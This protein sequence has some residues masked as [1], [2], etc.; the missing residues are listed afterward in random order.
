M[1]ICG[2]HI[3]G[4]GIFR[5]CRLEDLPKGLVLVVGQNESG[6]TTLMEFIR[7][8]LFGFRPRAEN[9]YPPLRGGAHGGRIELGSRDG[10]RF[11]VERRGKKATISEN[12]GPPREQEPASLL[13]GNI[14]RQTFERVFAIGLSDLQKLDVL[15]NDAF[16]GQLLSAGVGLGT[17]S[18]PQ[19]RK[20]L[21][22]ELD[23]LLKSRANQEI[24]KLKL[25]LEQIEVQLRTQR[26]MAADYAAGQHARSRLETRVAEHEAEFLQNTIRMQRIENLSRMR[27]PWVRASDARNRAQSLLSAKRCPPNAVERLDAIKGELERLQAAKAETDLRLRQIESQSDSIKVE[28]NLLMEA[29]AIEQLIAEREKLAAAINDL[30]ERKGDLERE[31]AALRRRLMDLGPDWTV[32]RLA[33]ADVS[34]QSRQQVQ[35]FDRFLKEAER[36]Q[37]EATVRLQALRQ[38]TPEPGVPS[39]ISSAP[40]ELVPAWMPLVAIGVSFGLCILAIAQQSWLTGCEFLAMG[41]AAAALLFWLKRRVQN[42][43]VGLAENEQALAEDA[44][45]RVQQGI[46]KMRDAVDEADKRVAAVLE[47]WNRWLV[48]H[49]FPAPAG[50]QSARPESFAVVLQAIDAARSAGE[51]VPKTRDRLRTVETYVQEA[52]HRIR[53]LYERLGFALPSPQPG[54]DAIVLLA[55]EFNRNRKAVEDRKAL[56]NELE[57]LR[58]ERNRFDSQL[59]EQERRLKAL[60]QEAGVADEAQLRRLADEYRAFRGYEEEIRNADLEMQTIA[61]SHARISEL[62]AELQGCDPVQLTVETAALRDR[63]AECNREIEAANREIGKITQTL[64]DMAHDDRMSDLLLQ[65]RGLCEQHADAIKRWATLAICR[66]LIDKALEVHERDRQPNVMRHAD[67]FL[68]IL[69]DGRYRLLAAGDENSVQ[70]ERVTSI[71]RTEELAWSSGLADQVFLA[72]RMGLAREFGLHSEPLPLILDDIDVRFDPTRKTA[73]TKLILEFA[74]EQQVLLFSCDPRMAEVVQSVYQKLEGERPLVGFIRLNDGRATRFQTSH[75][76]KSGNGAPTPHFAPLASDV[77]DP[78]L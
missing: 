4:F 28:S 17:L 42:Q 44:A 66:S 41:L 25:K 69:A 56:L 11:L 37:H 73:A 72:T 45:T 65:Q 15:S 18:L 19:V 29:S 40:F 60:F 21:D 48:D 31:E 49:D 23:K 30:P 57:R 71:E 3:D 6:K 43:T 14:D 24:G 52:G 67:S 27:E 5:D 62:G 7:T 77:S 9:P 36:Q 55:E 34:V 74:R 8:V 38:A 2:L 13:L 61:G 63:L 50:Q 12:G 39:R 70:L 54:V 22:A 64:E 51:T 59:S 32:E 10:R 76:E 46:G 33:R 75:L 58:M 20:T 47:K 68:K 1:H 26:A 16:R 53:T 35:E 78:I